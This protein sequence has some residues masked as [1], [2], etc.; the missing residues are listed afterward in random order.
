MSENGAQGP[1]AREAAH[2]KPRV[3]RLGPVSDLSG[4]V[5]NGEYSDPDVT[6]S[7]DGEIPTCPVSERTEYLIFSR[8]LEVE[9][10]SPIS[11]SAMREANPGIT[12]EM[13]E[14][15]VKRLIQFNYHFRLSSDAF[16]NA[17][18]YFDVVLSRAAIAPPDLELC[19]VCCYHVSAKV[20]TRIRLT[21]DMFNAVLGSQFTTRDFVLMEQRIVTAVDCELSFPTPKMFLRRFSEAVAASAEVVE[22]SNVLVEIAILMFGFVGTRP[23][24]LAG[25]VLSVAC[26]SV[27]DFASARRVI[28]EAR[29]DPGSMRESICSLIKV[30]KRIAATPVKAES[31]AESLIALMHFEFD[32]EAIV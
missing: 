9:K 14:K 26:A 18:V 5:P 16:H 6:D 23:S 8:S 19:A 29:G 13:R 4:G 30:G 10:R 20:D 11:K 21:P 15:A 32:A 12:P 3:T 1:A 31:G 7:S 17:V 24:V 25:A 28:V 2:A 27:G 22:I